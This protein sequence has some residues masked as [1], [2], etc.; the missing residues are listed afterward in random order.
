MEAQLEAMKQQLEMQDRAAAEAMPA[1]PTEVKSVFKV[2][3]AL[4]MLPVISLCYTVLFYKT[5]R[6]E[7]TA[8]KYCHTCAEILPV[9]GN[10]PIVRIGV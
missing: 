4:A 6:D 7:S 10:S 5:V 1:M 2:V 9:H 3:K 8:C